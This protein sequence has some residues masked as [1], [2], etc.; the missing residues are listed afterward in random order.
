MKEKRKNSIGGDKMKKRNY[1]FQIINRKTG[2]EEFREFIYGVT[3]YK[4]LH[5]AEDYLENDPRLKNTFKAGDDIKIIISERHSKIS[6][7]MIWNTPIFSNSSGYFKG[8]ERYEGGEKFKGV[9]KRKYGSAFYSSLGFAVMLFGLFAFT[10]VLATMDDGS[11][12]YETLSIASSQLIFIIGLIYNSIAS[13]VRE[14]FNAPAENTK[15]IWR[16]N[17]IIDLPVF[18]AIASTLINYYGQGVDVEDIVTY[19]TLLTSIAV[20]FL[21]FKVGLEIILDLEQLNK[22]KLKG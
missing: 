7:Q 19:N 14:D 17:L 13:I 9:K 11:Q 20:F 15:D 5:I 6:H 22:K 4:A 1:L 12:K 16:N 21:A 10:I 3:Y 2:E 18:I 8:W